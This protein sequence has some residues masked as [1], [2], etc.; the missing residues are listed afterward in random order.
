MTDEESPLDERL[1]GWKE[2]ASFVKRDEST[3]RRWEREEGLPVRR[4]EHRKR[5]SVYAY[6]RELEAW[7]VARGPEAGRP[8]PRLSPGWISLAIAGLMLFSRGDGFRALAEVNPPRRE[9]AGVA[10]ASRLRPEALR[11]ELRWFAPSFGRPHGHVSRDGRLVTYV[12]WV[13]GGNLAIRNLVA[14]ESRL[15]THTADNGE[16]YALE[17][18]ISPDGERVLYSWA[19]S[20]PAGETVEIRLLSLTG[21]EPRVVW[22][23]E[24]GAYASVQDWFPSGD[25]VVAIVGSS[26]TSRIVTVSLSDGRVRQIRSVGWAGRDPQVRVSRDGRYLAYSRS[27]SQD[28]PERDIFLVA[29]DGSR[30]IAVTQH[31]GR[32]ELVG[33]SPGG[34]YLLFTSDRSGQP[35]LWA[36][37]VRDGHPEGEP[38]LVF[39]NLDAGAGLGITDDGALHYAVTVT[40]R[41]MKLTEIDATSG[42][43]LRPPANVVDRFVGGNVRGVF[44][45]DGQSLVYVSERQ[46]WTRH[47]IVIRSLASG[48]ETE[49]ASDLRGVWGLTWSPDGQR[50][51]VQ[52]QDE[53]GRYGLFDLDVSSG[54]TKLLADVAFYAAFTPQGDHVLHR[55]AHAQH[56]SILSYSVTDGSVQTLPGSFPVRGR[57]SLSPDGRW[58]AT[59][60]GQTGTMPDEMYGNQIRLQPLTGGESS[61]LWSVGDGARLGRWTTWL[62]DGTALLVL[63]DEPEAGRGMWRLWIVPVDGSNPVATELVHE[64]ANFGS[65]PVSV[66]PDGK[67]I[68]YTE[69]GY[70][71]QLWALRA[72]PL[73][74]AD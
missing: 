68:V 61:A 44:S 31:A 29:V 11:T 17:S 41:R 47:V 28:V 35:G 14:A 58:I 49:L 23:P 56:G 9:P 30:E 43:I 24:E 5:S 53:L 1:E 10:A 37:R 62:P 73:D 15:L 36:Q 69:G 3:A 25:R 34:G 18:R 7:R 46:G 8:G 2:I 57:F 72:L 40:R 38:R 32:D 33:W 12:D 63:K 39:T 74:S 4:H 70:H 19:R 27:V 20:S 71:Y 51:V 48:E 52:G 59:I 45:P 60:A 67:R 6:R 64:P 13:N 42:R 50:L 16:H 55:S 26:S 21:G 54:R 65:I 22:T 66:H